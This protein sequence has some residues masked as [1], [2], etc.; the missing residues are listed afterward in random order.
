MKLTEAQKTANKLLGGDSTHIMLFGGSRSG[1][2]VLFVRAIII[3]ALK[4]S[5]SR[6]VILRFRFNHLKA[7]I[8][9]DTFPKVMKLCFPDVTY[10]M[11]KTDWYV[12][13][14]NGSVITFGGLDDRDRTEKIL[15]Q[16]YST[17]YLN[18]CSQISKESRDVA[19]TRLAQKCLVDFD[20]SGKILPLKMYYDCNPGSKAHWSYLLFIRKISPDSR[21]KLSNPD[22]WASMQMNPTDNLENL[23]KGYLDTLGQ[24]SSNMRTRFLHGV[25]AEEAP[26]ALWTEPMIEKWRVDELP[27]MQ[28]VIVGI[29]PSGAG[30]NDN[31]DNDAIGIIVGGIG[32]DG[33]AYVLEDLTMKGGPGSWGKAAVSA[34]D[35]HM[36]DLIVGEKNY[37]G[38]MVRFVVQSAKPGVPFKAVH[39]SRGKVVRA[40]PISALCERGKIR[41]MGKF[42]GLEEEMCSCTTSGYAGP[43]SPNRLD[44]FVWVMTELFPSIIKEKKERKTMKKQFFNMGWMN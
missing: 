25:F 12:T 18:E 29:D 32:V 13:F 8:I 30:D 5:F 40:E 14:P 28:R 22:D 36:A 2:T 9:Q 27:D 33:N 41:F 44:A 39:A 35:R 31:A 1:K 16:E 23:P 26:N 38:D 43:D 42:I 20:G 21:V 10:S 4:A 19:A 15:G 24:L 7:A 17:I 11:D 34:Y 37:G 6:H 3:R